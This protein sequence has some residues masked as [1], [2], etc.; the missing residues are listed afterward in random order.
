MDKV[1]AKGWGGNAS[2]CGI[3]RNGA[4]L[5]PLFLRDLTMQVT[6]PMTAVNRITGSASMKI[7]IV[8]DVSVTI[9]DENR[10]RPTPDERM[11][12]PLCSLCF[13]RAIAYVIRQMTAP[14]KGY[15]SR[16]LRGIVPPAFPSKS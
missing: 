1:Y 16:I 6:K 11:L 7:G 10:I 13:I 14:I 9:A 4:C 12:R 5:Q 8:P 3:N 2:V 15:I